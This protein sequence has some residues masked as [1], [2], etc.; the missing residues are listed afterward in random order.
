MFHVKHGREWFRLVASDARCQDPGS[1][2]ARPPN[3]KLVGEHSCSR[4]CVN[5]LS[6]SSRRINGSGLTR[7]LGS[8]LVPPQRS[9]VHGGAPLKTRMVGPFLSGLVSQDRSAES[10]LSLANNA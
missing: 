7:R 8:L 3:L 4:S 1:F 9:F 6:T 2:R 5:P 10:R